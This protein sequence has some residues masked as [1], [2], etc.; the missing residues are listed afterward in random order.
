MENIIE[1]ENI[2]INIAK[3]L[4]FNWYDVIWYWNITED[5]KSSFWYYSQEIMHIKKGDKEYYIDTNGESKI[6]WENDVVYNN[7]STYNEWLPFT[8]ENWTDKELAKIEDQWYSWS[9]NNWYSIYDKDNS[10]NDYIL[11]DDFSAKDIMDVIEKY[12][13]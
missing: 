13:K 8:L 5:R 6:Y 3:E 2:L 1:K 10:L 7:G 12:L 9:M 11:D 4:E